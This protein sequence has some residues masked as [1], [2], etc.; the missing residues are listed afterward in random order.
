[1]DFDP[2]ARDKGE[3]IVNQHKLALEDVRGVGMRGDGARGN[4]LFIRSILHGFEELVG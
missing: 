4:V 2:E 3:A 1:V